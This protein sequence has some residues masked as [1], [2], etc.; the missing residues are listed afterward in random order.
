MVKKLFIILLVCL[1]LCGCTDAPNDQTTPPV[2]NSTGPQLTGPGV[3]DPAVTT[4]AVTDPAVTTPAVTDP[5]VTTPA[6]TDPAVT[7]P[8][9]TG[10]AVT[11]PAV[12]EPAV[13][14][15]AVTDPLPTTT[16]PTDPA[17]TD[18]VPTDPVPTDPVPTDPVTPPPA[19]D[20]SV[21]FQVKYDESIEYAVIT[22]IA[23]DGS[24]AWTYTSGRYPMGMLA[25]LVEVGSWGDRFYYVESGTLVA[26]KLSDGSV[27]WKN[28]ELSGTPASKDACYIAANGDIYICGYLGPDIFAANAQGKTLQRVDTIDPYYFWPH[29]LTDIGGGFL[30]MTMEGNGDSGSGDGIKFYYSTNRELTYSDDFKMINALLKQL[31]SGN[32]IKS[33]SVESTFYPDG[34]YLLECS[35]TFRD[36]STANR[37]LSVY[38]SVS[39]FREG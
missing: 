34:S 39:V 4:P 1:L 3:T 23:K 33:T 24:T 28:S 9:V 38:P 31:Y 20:I 29:K 26:L 2:S 18:P 12:T 22:G 19:S 10:P 21:Q 6:V 14:T 11:T 37:T 16:P 35:I 13:T 30:A 5:E 7:T 27:L 36:G 32:T 17:P 25:S 15:P 8:A